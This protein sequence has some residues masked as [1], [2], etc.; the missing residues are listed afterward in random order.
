MRKTGKSLKGLW[1]LSSLPGKSEGGVPAPRE[2]C[3][4]ERGSPESAWTAL[5][6][7]SGKS[8]RSL[9][10]LDHVG[11]KLISDGSD[12]CRASLVP[13]FGLYWDSRSAPR[14]PP[15]A[16][17]QSR[18]GPPLSI[19]FSPPGCHQGQTRFPQCW[20]SSCPHGLPPFSTP[21][22]RQS[23]RTARDVSERT[24]RTQIE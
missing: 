18:S 16:G 20:G 2:R 6:N 7:S 19:T 4:T 14:A 3:H 23:N 12:L 21:R 10:V 11:S 17:L 24:Q 1:R 13:R 9:A 8:D 5:P 22:G 15:G